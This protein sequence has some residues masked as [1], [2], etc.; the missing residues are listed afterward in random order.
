MVHPACAGY[1]ILPTTC[2]SSEVLSPVFYGTLFQKQIPFFSSEDSSEDEDD[3]KEDHIRSSWP[4]NDL[5]F[6]D[7]IDRFR[8]HRIERP[9][10]ECHICVSIL[11]PGCPGC[12]NIPDHFLPSVYTSGKPTTASDEPRETT[13]ELPSS[14]SSSLKSPERLLVSTKSCSSHSSSTER[15]YYV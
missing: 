14:S 12:W 2:T 4:L 1:E 5:D 3:D 11:A 8:R 7:R 6:Q 10:R 15:E 9:S 13:A